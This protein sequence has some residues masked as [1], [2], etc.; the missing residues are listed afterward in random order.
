MLFVFTF[1][2][3][4]GIVLLYVCTRKKIQSVDIASRYVPCIF[5]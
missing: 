2:M 4:M 3:C 5:K 1:T